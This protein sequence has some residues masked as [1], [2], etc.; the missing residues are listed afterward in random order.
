MDKLAYFLLYIVLLNI[1]FY[2]FSSGTFDGSA[3]EYECEICA[4]HVHNSAKHCG[5][6]NRCVDGFDHHCR[7]LNNCVGKANYK[8]FFRLII[9][10]F[11]IT[12]LHNATNIPVLYYLS[13]ES[14]HTTD[15]HEATYKKILLT[16]FE[17][18]IGI[19]CF[20]NLLALA[21]LGHLTYFHI[22]L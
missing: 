6:C 9:M 17:I 3:Y 22:M 4:T 7:W 16:E 19:A 2:R 20:F 14:D 15:A 13:T 1:Q 10:V 8:L 5:T 11:L 12:L 18:M 21:F